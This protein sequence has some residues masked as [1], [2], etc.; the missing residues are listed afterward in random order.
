MNETETDEQ[1]K[2]NLSGAE[3]RRST[4]NQDKQSKK[5][6]SGALQAGGRKRIRRA[7]LNRELPHQMTTNLESGGEAAN[8]GHIVGLLE[9]VE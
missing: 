1:E 2:R 3:P 4:P 8:E 9:D 6:N 5:N 7:T